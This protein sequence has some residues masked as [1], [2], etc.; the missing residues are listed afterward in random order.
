MKILFML[1]PER[2]HINPFIGPAQALQ[3]LGHEVSI[4]SAGDLAAQMEKCGLPFLYDLVDPASAHAPKGKALVDL[5]ED[6]TQHRA[7][8]ENV[9]I[10]GA[11]DQVAPIQDFL[12]RHRPDVAVIDPMHYAAV[13]A[14]RTLNI[15]WVAMSSC[16]TSVLPDDLKSHVLDLVESLRAEREAVFKRFGPV[17]DFRA[18]EALSPHLNISFSTPALVANAPLGVEMLGPSF[19]LHERGDEVPLKPIPYGLDV[20]YASFGSQIFYYPQIFKKIQAAMRELKVHLILSVGELADELGWQDSENVQFYKYAPQMEILKR[21]SL[22]ITHGGANSVMEGLHAGVPLLISPMCNDQF[23][24]AIFVERSGV[25]QV[26]DLRT[27]SVA[28]V[29]RKVRGI[30]RDDQ[31]K[32]SV[33][34]VSQTYQGN[35]ALKAADL[36]SACF[37]ESYCP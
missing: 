36:I 30:L 14:A 25:G 33:N 19:P 21:A 13:I 16:L 34:K 12:R 11:A 31:V 24:Q 4:A 32:E 23:H 5:I 26:L 20:V 7:L 37:K 10:R 27:A 28:D 1:I 22:F 17:P 18:V 9:F 35:G 3:K 15:P 6:R 2:G 8:I 29:L